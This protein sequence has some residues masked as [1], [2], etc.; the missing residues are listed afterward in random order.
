MSSP[1]HIRRPQAQDVI[2]A[3]FDGFVEMLGDGKQQKDIC[4]Q[5]GW[6]SSAALLW[7]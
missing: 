7:W 6:P 4:M 2:Q 5:V 3:V 1:R